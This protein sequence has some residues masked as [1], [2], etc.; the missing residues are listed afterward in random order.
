[1]SRGSDV[2]ETPAWQRRE[3]GG[4]W[5]PVLAVTKQVPPVQEVRA[6]DDCCSRGVPLFIKVLVYLEPGELRGGVVP[7]PGVEPG[8]QS[9]LTVRSPLRSL[10]PGPGG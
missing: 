9:P 4:G 6:G 3:V 1:M 2:M 7:R 10:V 8:Q 5:K